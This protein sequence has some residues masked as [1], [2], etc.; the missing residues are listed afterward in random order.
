MQCRSSTPR[1]VLYSLRLR[2]RIVAAST[3][4]W[5]FWKKKNRNNRIPGWFLLPLSVRASPAA[6]AWDSA[7]LAA[8]LLTHRRVQGEEA[9]ARPPRARKQRHLEEQ[10]AAAATLCAGN[11]YLVERL[12]VA[13]ARAGLFAL[14][15]AR[16]GSAPGA[17]QS[18]AASPPRARPSP[19]TAPRRRVGLRWRLQRAHNSPEEWK[20]GREA[21]FFSKFFETKLGYMSSKT[22]DQ[23][24]NG[25]EEE[26][27]LY[28]QCKDY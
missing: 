8:H 17:R 23:A 12:R 4:Q 1:L 9:P 16:P 3:V 14:A 15:N 24:W 6:G 25:R 28:P 19:W 26:Y 2:P 22:V 20:R 5:H 7:A 27:S 10:R 18:A 13:R 21:F 11:R